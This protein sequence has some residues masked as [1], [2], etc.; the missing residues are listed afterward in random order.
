MAKL[1]WAF[2]LAML[3]GALAD[4]HDALLQPH[5]VT[6]TKRPVKLL[7]VPVADI[8]KVEDIVKTTLT[9]ARSSVESLLN[10][11][12][13]SSA[14]LATAYGELG[15]LYHVHHFYVTAE[16]SYRNAIALEPDNFRWVYDMSYLA[17]QTNQPEL[18][19]ETLRRA[20]ELRPDYMPAQ[21]KLALAYID[22]NQHEQAE[23][24]LQKTVEINAL[25]PASLFGLGEIALAR[26]NYQEA[27]QWLEQALSERPQA[28]R[29]HYPLA[30]AYRGLGELDRAKVHL[31]QRGDGKPEIEDPQVERLAKRL[32]GARTH[33]YRALEAVRTRRYPE[34]IEAFAAALK[35]QPDNVNARVSLARS[36]Y[37]NSEPRAA[38]AQLKEA[39]RRAPRHELANF[40]LGLLCD[41]QGDYTAAKR[42]Y[43]RTLSINPSHAGAHH[44][45]ANVLFREGHYAEAAKHFAEA[46]KLVPRNLPARLM[47]I[48][49]MLRSGAAHADVKL[50][51]EAL[52]S[53]FTEQPI[54]TYVLIRLLAASPDE[55]VRDGHR[56]LA[57][58]KGLKQAARYPEYDETLA[59]IEAELGRY[60][61]AITTQNKAIIAAYAAGRLDLLPR[62]DEILEQYRKGQPCRVPWSPT[63]PIF[64]PLP[65]DPSGPFRD[66]PTGASY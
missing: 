42:Y 13:A 35:E 15:E 5:T 31:D 30:L 61:E 63:D 10:S 55:T 56:A 32:T 52:R 49:A 11:G 23:P 26:R 37:L 41:D 64:Q 17:E 53:E 34:A 43:Q 6:T 48:L 33:F 66:Y 20:I 51:L 65:V 60:D 58:L 62:L 27:V 1:C 59:M 8:S 16:P 24:L 22:L 14:E 12:K 19:V 45:L 46:G 54:F 47:E 25:R 2:T 38:L 44:Y 39:L 29:I 21:L 3:C 57:L 7:P 9:T 40:L 28:S 50:R 36:L 18:V 4:A